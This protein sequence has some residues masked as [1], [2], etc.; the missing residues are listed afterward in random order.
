[1]P[2]KLS[3]SKISNYEKR[4]EFHRSQAGTWQTRYMLHATSGKPGRARNAQ[5]QYNYHMRMLADILVSVTGQPA[6]MLLIP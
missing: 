5:A 6:Q 3:M 2:Q 1:L 4:A